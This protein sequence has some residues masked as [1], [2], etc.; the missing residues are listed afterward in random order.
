MDAFLTDWVEW[1]VHKAMFWEKDDAR[2]GRILRGV[3]HALAITMILMII[4][5]HT[6]FRSFW[7]QTIVLIVLMYAWIHHMIVGDCV[8][9][10]IENKLLNDEASFWDA[11]IEFFGIKPTPE[12][13]RIVL[14]TMSTTGFACLSLEWVA[15]V[16]WGLSRIFHPFG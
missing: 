2:K 6:L 7:L 10:R 1:A 5:S 3:H 8:V 15:N 14:L 11:W 12:I 13:A 9:S 4:L 16:L